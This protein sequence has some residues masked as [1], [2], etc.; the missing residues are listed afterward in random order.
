M[1]VVRADV[2]VLQQAGRVV[3]EQAVGPL[4][5]LQEELPAPGPREVDGDGPLVAA[6]GVEPAQPVPGVVS[7][8][9]AGVVASDGAG[10]RAVPASRMPGTAAGGG[11]VLKGF[12]LDDLRPHVGQKH[13]GERPRQGHRQVDDADALERPERWHARRLTASRR[14]PSGWVGQAP[15]PTPPPTPPPTPARSAS[16]RSVSWPRVGAVRRR[17]QPPP[18]VRHGGPQ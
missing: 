8:V 15:A 18:P 5:Q 11:I 16:T 6:M 3:F 1:E 13:G 7:G 4:D 2:E 14:K 17:C 10:H 12:D 9:V